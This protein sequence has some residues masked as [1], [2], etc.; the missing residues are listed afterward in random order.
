MRD[1]AIAAPVATGSIAVNCLEL[2]LTNMYWLAF[3]VI[4]RKGLR[5]I[6]G[7]LRKVSE[8]QALLIGIDVCVGYN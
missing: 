3:R 4:V 8:G 2:R 6:Y 5:R 1:A 7:I